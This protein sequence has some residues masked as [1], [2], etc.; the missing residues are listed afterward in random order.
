MISL[1]AAFGLE[2]LLFSDELWTRL[3]VG[4][5]IA[6]I[7]F[8]VCWI[9]ITLGTDFSLLSNVYGLKDSLVNFTRGLGGMASGPGSGA[10]DGGGEGR[11]RVR[12]QSRSDAFKEALTRLRPRRTRASTSATLVHSS[13][14][15]DRG[16]R[17]TTVI[18]MD[19]F[20]GDAV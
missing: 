20:E 19:K 18:E 6:M 2:V 4:I 12:R 14:S 16:P 7:I 17:A 3:P 8:L 10:G 9:F 5:L 1:F 13:W 15:N 11:G